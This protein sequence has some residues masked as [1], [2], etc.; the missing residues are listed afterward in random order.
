M[1]N[2]LP[3]NSNSRGFTLIEVIIYIGLF[4]IFMSGAVVA[5][6]ELVQSGARNQEAVSV[7]EEGTF[8]IRKINWALSGASSATSSHSTTLSVYMPDGSK[9]TIWGDGSS[10]YLSHTSGTATLANSLVLNASAY[11]VTNLVF[12]TI[13]T[14][15]TKPEFISVNFKIRN[16][17]FTLKTYLR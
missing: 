1:K 14:T 3:K 5:T 7:Q 12:S 9:R 15:S 13:S 2:I 8:I 16:R 11:P 6:F 10:I 4:A 17:S